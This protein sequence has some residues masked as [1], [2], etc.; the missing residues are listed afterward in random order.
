MVIA[1]IICL[2]VSNRHL[3]IF[4]LA[5]M[6]AVGCRRDPYMDAYFEMLNAEKRVLEDRLYEVQ[7]D[8][9]QALAELE[10]CRNSTRVASPFS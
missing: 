10:T 6:L 2:V 7:Y 4:L 5:C 3:C 8:Y 1:V 9:E